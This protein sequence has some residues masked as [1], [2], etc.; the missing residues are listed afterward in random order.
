MNTVPVLTLR[1]GDWKRHGLLKQRCDISLQWVMN[2]MKGKRLHEYMTG[3]P[4]TC[5]GS[6][7]EPLLS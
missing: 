5:A 4:R 1:A 2:T 3:G 7:S 6:Q